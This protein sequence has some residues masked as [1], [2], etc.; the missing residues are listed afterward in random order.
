M[1]RTR[2]SGRSWAGLVTSVAVTLAAGCDGE[3]VFQPGGG[4]GGS[5]SVS[6]DIQDPSAD[7]TSHSIGD[8]LLVT[9]RVSSGRG[10]QTVTYEAFALRGDPDLGTQQVV[11]RFTPKTVDLMGVVTDTVLSRYLQ[12]TEG[13]EDVRE[14][15]LVVVKAEDADGAIASDTAEVLLGGTKVELLDI[16]DGQAIQ[17][18]LSLAVRV[19]GTDPDGV[20]QLQLDFTGA[21]QTT[22]L[23]SFNPAVDSAAMDTVVAIPSGIQ[24]EVQV[25]A[26]ARNTLDLVGVAGPFTLFVGSGGGGDAAAPTLSA[27]A[28]SEPRL[29]L[30]DVV[31]VTVSGRDNN[32]G[33][34][35]A[36]A[37]YTVK[38]ISPSRGDTLVQSDDQVYTPPRTG[39]V[40]G[41]FG[42]TPFN[43]DSLALPDTLVFEVTGY[44]IDGQGN[45][46]ASVGGG[47][48]PLPCSTLPGGEIVAQD[49]AGQRLVRSI[50]AGRTVFLPAGGEI[51]D[52]EVDTI[53]R[54]LFLSNHD[55]DR[56]EVFGL[57]SESFFR[58]IPVGSEPWGLDLTRGEDTLMVANSG[59]TNISNIYL[60][61]PVNLNPPFQDHTEDP[62]RRIVTPD[63]VLFD[64]ERRVD[65]TGALRYRVTFH[66]PGN[67]SPGFS[68]RP[69]FMAVDSTGRVL[70][71]TKTTA[72]GDFG[73]IRR[74]WTP[75][76]GLRLTEVK[77]FYEHGELIEAPDFVAIANV[78][79]IGITSTPLTDVATVF[80]HVAGDTIAIF[81]DPPDLIESA[82]SAARDA[83][84]DVAIFS[85]RWSVPNIGFH[86]TTYV[87][88]SGDR[89]WVVFGEGSVEPV[90]RVIMYEAATD[91]LS[92]VI[93]VTDLLNNASERVRG[94]SLN[95]DGTLGV[96]RGLQ[97]YFFSTD[98]RLQGVADLPA[99]GAGAALHPLH[100]DFP[101]RNNLDGRYDPDTHLAFLGTGER[102]VDIIDAFH[103]NRVGRLFIKDVVAGPLQAV[104]PFPEDNASFACQTKTVLNGTGQVIGQ[105]VD[106]YAD[107]QGNIPYPAVGGPTDDRCVV[108][109][110]FGITANGGVVVVDVRKGDIL[111][112]HPAR[113]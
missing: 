100:A 16:V 28:T 66:P 72:L 81:N 83:G 74:A 54:N 8:S 112:E 64:V 9:A 63:V 73:T 90:G 11:P 21:F 101:S 68:D 95:H 46:A 79:H 94:V 59:G 56:I 23:K 19:R 109:K 14:P 15:I 52:A 88:A 25:L 71:S 85:G 80:D 42:F 60:G 7:V 108:V 40:V 110:L 34:G 38:A 111:K 98:L 104:L 87:A 105:A 18:G 77:L 37:G 30:K 103:F 53:R 22:I 12:P 61:P 84:S 113:Q 6:V 41:T 76:T 82:A 91:R 93:P 78:D 106:I 49:R 47:S 13:D 70:Y 32:P 62:S 35:V 107:A 89:G 31:T 97:A 33:S 102:T 3:N 2:I 43:V 27:E 48:D 58:P 4:L 92:G 50:V 36:R 86:D 5:A 39:N 1:S 44:M 55:R 26:S 20:L 65:D 45:C 51:L 24:G 67:D 99:G 29:E 69:Q 75:N 96:A 10:I 17:A 57:Q